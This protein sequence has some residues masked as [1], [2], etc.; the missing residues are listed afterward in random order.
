MFAGL[1][2]C[3]GC[4]H[5]LHNCRRAGFAAQPCFAGKCRSQQQAGHRNR[6]SGWK[7]RI[8]EKRSSPFGLLLY[9]GMFSCVMNIQTGFTLQKRCQYGT[10]VLSRKKLVAKRRRHARVYKG[11]AAASVTFCGKEEWRSGM[12]NP[13][14]FGWGFWMERS[15]FRRGKHW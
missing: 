7:S 12:R 1:L 5:K 10:I 13:Q 6:I 11:I 9:I 14:P 3:A 2:Y 15:P 4:G 8:N